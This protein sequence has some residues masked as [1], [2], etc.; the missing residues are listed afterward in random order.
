MEEGQWLLFTRFSCW[1]ASSQNLLT[2]LTC[3]LKWLSWLISHSISCPVHDLWTPNSVIFEVEERKSQISPKIY[4]RYLKDDLKINSIIRMDA[5]ALDVAYGTDRI[6][7]CWC[8]IIVNFCLK[9]LVYRTV[10]IQIDG[11]L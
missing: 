2:H 9:A 7:S 8:V 6:E 11:H 1:V 5:A 3:F 10:P 4:S